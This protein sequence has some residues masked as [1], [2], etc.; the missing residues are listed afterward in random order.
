M[1]LL[2]YSYLILFMAVEINSFSQTKEEID[3]T[4]EDFLYQTKVNEN[5]DSLRNSMRLWDYD[6]FTSAL[7]TDSE[8]TAF[9][10]NIYNAIVQDEL[11]KRPELYLK[12]SQFFKKKLV[13]IAG[14]SLSPDDI[15]HGI[16]RKSSLKL[17][18]GY[19]HKL[20]PNKTEK[21]WR[22]NQVDPRIHFALNCGAVSCPAINWYTAAELNTQLNL[23]SESYLSQAIAYNSKTNTLIIPKLFSW[24]RGDFNGKKGIIK[25]IQLHLN[26]D[27]SEFKRIEFAPYNWQLQLKSYKN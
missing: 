13:E 1:H 27:I 21:Q 10:L 3:H 26:R 12:R 18:L 24:F 5:T 14:I 15:E 7:K 25:F 9:W 16:L 20:F 4:S 6:T 22:V 23:A 19:L 8:K 11:S 17:S 2:K